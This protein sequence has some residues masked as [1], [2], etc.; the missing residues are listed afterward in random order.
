M[1]LHNLLKQQARHC[2]GKLAALLKCGAIISFQFSSLII[3]YNVRTWHI[4][5]PLP[6][7]ATQ[8]GDIVLHY[9]KCL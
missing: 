5:D 2:G 4:G 6:Y 1:T 3:Q 8:A 7:E 9:C